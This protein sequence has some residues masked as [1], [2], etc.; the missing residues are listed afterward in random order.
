SP[1][2][3]AAP[4]AL[5]RRGRANGGRGWAQKGRNDS[6][7][8]SRHRASGCVTPAHS[9][10][11]RTTNV[12]RRYKPMSISQTLRAVT[13]TSALAVTAPAGAYAA[14]LGYGAFVGEFVPP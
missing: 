11:A 8:P 2:E 9:Y 1:S 7:L 5:G 4:A 12:P 10:P 6:H 3:L 14:S 13:F